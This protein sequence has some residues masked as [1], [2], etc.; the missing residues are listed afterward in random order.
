MDSNWALGV[1]STA[2]RSIDMITPGGQRSVVDLE[3]LTKEGIPASQKTKRLVFEGEFSSWQPGSAEDYLKG[4]GFALP[5]EVVHR[6]EVFTMVNERRWTIHVPSLVLMRAFFKPNPLVFPAIYTP[7]GV[8]Y[9]SFVD[10]SAT[11]PK[12]V[13]DGLFC[14]NGYVTKVFSTDPDVSQGQPLRWIQLSKS[15]KRASLSAYQHAVTG[16]LNLSLP[17]GRVRM[18]FHGPIK[19]KHLYAT[20]ASLIS[21]DVDEEDSITG[22]GERFAFHPTAN[23]HREPKTSTRN[24]TVPV[25]PHGGY[26]LT[27]GEWEA[28][29][30]ILKR[31]FSNPI[32]SQR[33]LLNVIF[34][35]LVSGIPWNKTPTG[36]FK[37]TTVTSTFH[38]LVSSGRMDQVLA[39]LEES[40]EAIA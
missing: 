10:Y 26:E 2:P 16:W 4:L 24:L 35:K 33:E 25:H 13:V 8:D 17:S 23:P 5:E 40:R 6:H 28:I 27:D 39:Y 21:V 1:S 22:A 11:P 36:G 31:K 32:H 15:A 12:V 20:K 34:N 19:G 14:G 29:E 30:P 9:I 37:V 7:I 18:V 3:A 38:Y